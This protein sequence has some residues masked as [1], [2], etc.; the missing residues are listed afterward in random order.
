MLRVVCQSETLLRRLSF[1]LSFV[2][3]V[4]EKVEEILIEKTERRT[5]NWEFD[6][7]CDEFQC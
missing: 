7:C 6:L 1:F 5:S 2:G 3:V 4:R